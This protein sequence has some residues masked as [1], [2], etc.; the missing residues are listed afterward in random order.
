MQDNV[1]KKCVN[2]ATNTNG[3]TVKW[4]NTNDCTDPTTIT[5]KYYIKDPNYGIIARCDTNCNSCKKK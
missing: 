2:C 5:D 3:L 1:N 4:E